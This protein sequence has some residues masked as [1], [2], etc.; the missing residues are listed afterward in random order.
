[1]ARNIASGND[2]VPVQV[3]RVLGRSRSAQDDATPP[4]ASTGQDDAP[5]TNTNIRSGNARV[6]RQAD[7]IDGGLTI[8]L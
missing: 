6:G 8:C 5:T 1:M 3:G 7:V 2:N 4:P